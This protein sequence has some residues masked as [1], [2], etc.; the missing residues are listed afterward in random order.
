[1]IIVTAAII[2]KDG[3]YLAARKRQGLHLEGLWEFPGGKLEP[4]ETPKQCLARE[5][6]EEFGATFTVGD[7]VAASTHNYGDKVIRLLG[8]HA[9]HT[10]GMLTL[11]DHDAIRW[12]DISE[13]E[14]L[15]WA[16]ADIPLVEAIKSAHYTKTT[17]SYYTA[18][19]EDYVSATRDCDMAAIRDEFSSRLPKS[20]HILDLGCGS[21]RDS[22]AFLAAGYTVTATDACPDI[23]RLASAYI[24]QPVLVQ[25]AQELE[26]SECFDGIWACASLLHVP[27][28]EFDDTL[29]RITR[30]LKQDGTLYMSFKLV[31]QNGTDAKGRY[32]LAHAAAVSHLETRGNSLRIERQYQT[33]SRMTCTSER[34]LNIL[35]C[36]L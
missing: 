9:T 2:E 1:M 33:S 32:Y 27:E 20:P 24:G 6:T 22:K 15:N 23:A 3:R 36:K 12:L 18:N 19:A 28:N 35:A 29:D 5:L 34:W 10:A 7:F 13:L 4:G 11:S 8:Y 16:P 21:G 30:A 14:H 25:K 17:I 31:E 26:G